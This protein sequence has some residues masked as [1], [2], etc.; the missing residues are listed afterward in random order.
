VERKSRINEKQNIKGET[1]NI[2]WK[3]I[4]SREQ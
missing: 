2:K 4:G 3:N 1:D